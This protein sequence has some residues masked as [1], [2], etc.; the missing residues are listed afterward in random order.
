MIDRED[1]LH[2]A[3]LC[4]LSLTEAELDQMSRELSQILEHV[5]KISEIDLW[6]VE[7]TSHV[8]GLQ[9]VLR[10]DI[11]RPSLSQNE[12]LGQAPDAAQGGFR[13]PPS[14]S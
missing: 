4:R 7:P 14:G 8:V 6:G 13:V 5:E 12:A 11:P 9:N 10:E 3:G 1:V 2:V